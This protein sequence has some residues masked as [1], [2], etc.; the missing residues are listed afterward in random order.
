MKKIIL[1]IVFALAFLIVSNLSVS[2]QAVNRI[3]QRC[4]SPNRN[5][6]SLI[7]AAAS[8]DITYLPCPSKSSIFYGLVDF[9]NATVTGLVGGSGTINTIPKFTAAST[10]GN[11]R[12]TDAGAGGNITINSGANITNIGDTSGIGAS[13][14]LSLDDSIGKMFFTSVACKG[15]SLDRITNNGRYEIGDIDGCVQGN[16]IRVT[17]STKRLDMETGAGGAAY[18]GDPAQV[19][20][21]VLLTVNDAASGTITGNATTYTLSDTLNTANFK[22]AFTPITGTTGGIINFGDPLN[23]T[24]ANKVGIFA[25]QGSHFM[26]LFGDT[27]VNIVS[28]NASMG[29]GD[30]IGNVTLF[31]VTDSTKTFLFSG[32]GSTAILDY[33]GIVNFKWQRTITAGGT[34]G[35]QTID[36]PNG[37]VN[38]AA[39]AVALVVTNN[40]VTTSSLINALA[41]TDDA[42]CSVKN[43]VAGAGSFTINM[44]AACTA[45]TKVAFWVTN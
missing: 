16:Y 24:P 33:A 9:T 40:T 26:N 7:E 12:I 27:G 13:T 31:S 20:S 11:S 38:F 2:A 41:Q 28:R 43:V 8:G 23:A 34:T 4:A 39:A 21:K 17:A 22:M 42:T 19:G 6:Y 45:E 32:T 25:F 30:A 10:I 36:K 35:A 37:S 44:T 3:T 29:D 5:V 15:F 14:K 1:S 18:I